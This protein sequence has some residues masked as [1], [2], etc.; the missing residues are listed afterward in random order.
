MR[1]G[2]G[3]PLI[4]YTRTNLRACMLY[5]HCVYHSHQAILYC[6]VAVVGADR[7]AVAVSVRAGAS[8]GVGAGVGAGMGAAV[9][10]GA[11]ALAGAAAAGCMGCG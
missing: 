11:G 9:G 1:E 7:G 2:R 5:N 8:A 3:L 6:V 4:M 10:A